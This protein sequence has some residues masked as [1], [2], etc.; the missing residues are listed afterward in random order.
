MGA[1]LLDLEAATRPYGVVGI[2][3]SGRKIALDGG[4]SSITSGGL[5]SVGALSSVMALDE[6]GRDYYVNMS[7]S[8]NTKKAT[9][10]FNPISRANFYEDINPF[11]K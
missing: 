6:F 8:T 4:F 11:I 10:N 2:P 3:T 9:G 5:A 7:G 1:G